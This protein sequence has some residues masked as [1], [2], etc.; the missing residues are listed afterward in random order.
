MKI[1]KILN[2]I[3][4]PGPESEYWDQL[5]PEFQKEYNVFTDFQKE[6]ASVKR[7]N[8]YGEFDESA[9]SLNLK[10]RQKD[11]ELVALIHQLHEFDKEEIAPVVEEMNP[12]EIKTKTKEVTKFQSSD[13]KVIEENKTKEEKTDVQ[14]TQNE[15]VEKKEESEIPP[16]KENEPEEPI[17]RDDIETNNPAPEKK[18]EDSKESEKEIKNEKKEEMN[19]E[20]IKTET[21]EVTELKKEEITP[22]VEEKIEEKII[23]VNPKPDYTE[24]KQYLAENKQIS[25]KTLIKFGIPESVWKKDSYEFEFLD[26]VFRKTSPAQLM[27]YDWTIFRKTN[28]QAGL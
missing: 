16:I 20:E 8:K 1:N 25:A 12:E 9:K 24:F 26:Y 4:I 13:A 22:V 21:G 3:G 14:E 19:P 18:A 23:E 15:K 2:D 27:F 28:I 10:I 11:T 17:K 5:E 6:L 7:A